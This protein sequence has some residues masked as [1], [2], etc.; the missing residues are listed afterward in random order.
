MQF[1]FKIFVASSLLYGLAVQAQCFIGETNG[2]SR[3]QLPADPL[4]PFERVIIVLKNCASDC[5]PCC[6]EPANIAYYGTEHAC[7]VDCE[8]GC[9]TS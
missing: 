2:V 8:S 5:G 9:G 6:A 4:S 7:K 1:T 3:V